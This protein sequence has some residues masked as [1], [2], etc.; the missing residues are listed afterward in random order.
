MR[1][2]TAAAN[3][4]TSDFPLMMFHRCTSQVII[5]SAILAAKPAA[6]LN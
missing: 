3:A 6:K 2:M 4:F 5:I 1:S